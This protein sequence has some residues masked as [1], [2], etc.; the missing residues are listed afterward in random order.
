MLC[1]TGAAK[2][3]TVSR[4]FGCAMLVIVFILLFQTRLC[5]SVL[6][7]RAATNR[8]IRSEC[9]NLVEGQDPSCPE[10][11]HRTRE[12]HCELCMRRRGKRRRGKKVTNKACQWSTQEKPGVWCLPVDGF[13]APFIIPKNH[14]RNQ[15][16]PLEPMPKMWK[17]LV[18][19][20]GYVTG[21]AAVTALQHAFQNCNPGGFDLHPDVQ[22]RGSTWFGNRLYTVLATLFRIMMLWLC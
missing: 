16:G 5:S 15:G 4:G 10:M 13:R 1:D 2:L 9:S 7:V 8:Q 17:L 18:R 6:A 14:V 21:T 22:H 19:E 11:G 12:W 20:Y 3:A